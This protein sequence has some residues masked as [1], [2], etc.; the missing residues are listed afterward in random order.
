MVGFADF[1]LHHDYGPSNAMY[2]I[3]YKYST[4]FTLILNCEHYL[5]MSN[6]TLQWKTQNDCKNYG[7]EMHT[8]STLLQQALDEQKR[9]TPHH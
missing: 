8:S 4:L 1:N 5:D 2:G 7:R 9:N 3:Q 6:L